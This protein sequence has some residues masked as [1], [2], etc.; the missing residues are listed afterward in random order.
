LT[1]AIEPK[2]AI[3]RCTKLPLPEELYV[4]CPGFALASAMNSFTLFAGSAGCTTSMPICTL[5][6]ATAAKSLSV[7]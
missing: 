2:S 3:D 5:N 7:S 1:P 6:G 4:S